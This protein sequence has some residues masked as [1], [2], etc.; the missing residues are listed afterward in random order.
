M[1]TDQTKV[2]KVHLDLDALE[3]EQVFGLPEAQREPYTVNAGGRA[4]PF[5]DPVELNHLILA[6]MEQ[7]PLRFFK[8]VIEDKDDYQHFVRWANDAGP[9]GKKGLAGFKLRAL[10]EGY[11][12]YYGLDKMGNVAGS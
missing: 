2:S 11:R 1:S 7:T 9:D 3:R 12:D 4:I 5:R 8:A 6:Q 10:M